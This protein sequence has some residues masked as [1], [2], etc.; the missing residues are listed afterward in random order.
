MT[1]YSGNGFNLGN[2]VFDENN[3]E[4]Q[5]HKRFEQICNRSLVLFSR[6]FVTLLILARCIVKNNCCRKLRGTNSLDCYL[7]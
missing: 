4:Q 1:G 2:F 7:F 5:S 3:L 6:I